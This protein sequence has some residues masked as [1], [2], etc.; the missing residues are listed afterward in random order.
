M[1]KQDKIREEYLELSAHRQFTP[2]ERAALEARRVALRK[3]CTHP[4]IG[5]GMLPG[6]FN[7]PVA[8]NE[9]PD[10][11]YIAES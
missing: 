9:C 11:G 8:P 7:Q 1:S 10:C 6:N 4:N 3:R 2:E 5:K